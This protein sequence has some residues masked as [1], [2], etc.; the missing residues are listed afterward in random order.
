MQLKLSFIICVVM[1]GCAQKSEKSPKTDVNMVKLHHE[2]G[3]HDRYQN[4]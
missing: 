2:I 4:D 1:I 3:N